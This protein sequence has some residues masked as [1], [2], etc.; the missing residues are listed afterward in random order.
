[1]VFLWKGASFGS[2]GRITY[3][4]LH[5]ICYRCGRPLK[6]LKS[7]LLGYGSVC[8]QKMKHDPD[9]LFLLFEEERRKN[10]NN[11]KLKQIKKEVN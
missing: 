1:M 5:T 4:I 7:K 2:E 8:Y 6:S 11:N 10:S 3:M 9:L